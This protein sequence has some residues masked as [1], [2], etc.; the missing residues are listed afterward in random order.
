[1]TADK[2]KDEFSPSHHLRQ[3]H[4]APFLDC[5][6]CAD[7]AVAVGASAEPDSD[8]VC[9]DRSDVRDLVTDLEAAA[10]DLDRF[11]ANIADMADAED[12]ADVALHLCEIASKW[13]NDG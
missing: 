7:A 11:K 6:T 5:S 13:R 1:M 3:G 9:V 10:K 4:R 12:L 8:D 2:W